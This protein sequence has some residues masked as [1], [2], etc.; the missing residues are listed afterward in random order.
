MMQDRSEQV[1]TAELVE[2]D[3]EQVA[4]GKDNDIDIINRGPFPRPFPRPFPVRRLP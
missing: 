2:A 4:A 3:L 1:E